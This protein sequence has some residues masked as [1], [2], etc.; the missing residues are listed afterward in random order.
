MFVL[1]SWPSGFIL[2]TSVSVLEQMRFELAPMPFLV[3]PR[4]IRLVYVCRDFVSFES[5]HMEA[6]V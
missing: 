3:L 6:D 4:C 5:M 1:E 2:L